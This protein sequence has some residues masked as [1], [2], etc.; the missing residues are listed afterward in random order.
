MHSTLVSLGDSGDCPFQNIPQFDIIGKESYAVTSEYCLLPGGDSCP[1]C[2]QL[3]LPGLL[4]VL[5]VIIP[6]LAFWILPKYK[7]SKFFSGFCMVC[8]WSWV[9]KADKKVKKR[10]RKGNTKWDMRKTKRKGKDAEGEG[11]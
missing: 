11:K 3:L 9:L 7:A 10:K 6:I 8:H 1:F 5:I 4:L 2:L